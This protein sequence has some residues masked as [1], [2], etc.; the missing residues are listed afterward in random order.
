MVCDEDCGCR[1]Q[2]KLNVRWDEGNDRQ[3]E[4]VLSHSFTLDFVV[5]ESRRDAEEFLSTLEERFIK[6]GLEL[7]PERH[8]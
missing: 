2:G 5:C 8:E 1:I 4:M 3:L 6:F 7:S